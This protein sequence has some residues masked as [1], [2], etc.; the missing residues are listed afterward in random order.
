M[1][2]RKIK[3]N[4]SKAWKIQGY[5]VSFAFILL[6]IIRWLN[7]QTEFR[8]EYFWTTLFLLI[9]V[10]IIY[11]YV[12]KRFPHITEMSWKRVNI[13]LFILMVV[14]MLS[15]LPLLVITIGFLILLKPVPAWM[16]IAEFVLI[17]GIL[18][19]LYYKKRF[20]K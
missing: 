3:P 2:K 6:I 14:L 10:F 8:I 13:P 5:F 16:I 18:F 17:L 4:S 19:V 15:F 12:P 11:F 20:K 9:L 7:Y 1:L